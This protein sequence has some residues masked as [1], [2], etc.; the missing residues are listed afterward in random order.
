MTTKISI[1]DLDVKQLYSNEWNS[2]I[3][4]PE[5]EDRI[6][7]SLERF[8][9]FRPIIARQVKN[10]DGY[11][12][13]GGEHRWKVAS[14]MGYETIPVINLGYIDDKK[15]KEIGLVDN[16]RYGDDD[17]LMLS[18]LLKDL[19][20][21]DDL[22]SFMPYTNDELTNIFASSDIAFDDLGF[23]D[24][25]DDNTPP[26]TIAEK[27]I[28]THN[29]MR[30]KVPVE[31]S[32]FIETL[33]ETTMKKQGYTDDDSMMNAGNAIVHLLRGLK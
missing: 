7:A 9:M 12:I 10:Q 25:E 15:A 8:G 5:N 16:G 21:A 1:T 17:V 29:I 33:I 31:D 3:V 14:K 26:L 22:M 24:N 30:F 20:D 11:Q 6:K 23:D 28:Q 13:L 18:E 27:A 4:T 19:G 2:N 32:K